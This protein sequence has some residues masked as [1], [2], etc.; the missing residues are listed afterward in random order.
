MFSGS[1]H[2]EVLQVFHMVLEL[3]ALMI[4]LSDLQISVCF[5]HLLKHQN[6][7]DFVKKENKMFVVQLKRCL[8]WHQSVKYL[9]VEIETI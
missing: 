8:L 2:F 5:L 4:T 6:M 3:T 1:A 7:I 9:V